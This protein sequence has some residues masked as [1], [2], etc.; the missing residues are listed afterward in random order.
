MVQS[1]AQLHV[2]V[3]PDRRLVREQHPDADHADRG[4]G[5]HRAER[6]AARAER[7]ERAPAADQRQVEREVQDAEADA[8]PQ[9]RLGVADRAERAAQHE[10]EH[11]AHAA[12][13]DDAEVGQCFDL[14]VR[15][16]VDQFQEVGRGEPADRR[17]HPE[18]EDQGGEER[19]IDDPVHLVGI[20][21]AG[22]ARDE[23]GHAGVERADEDDD[24]QEDLPADANGRVAAV[25]G[26]M[27]DHGV[28]ENAL[29]P[30]HHVLDDGRPGQVPDGGEQG[31][32]D[33]P[34]VETL[35]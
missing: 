27:P 30:A 8:E 18:A 13:E 23:H 9:R 22:E 10:E 21:L 14:D 6:R 1:G 11:H 7:G 28:V 32:F 26:G 19:L 12:G 15:R 17:H 31:T 3:E 33:D 35:H 2:A 4:R 5:D 20:A 29:E 24:D 25:A 16:G 34:S